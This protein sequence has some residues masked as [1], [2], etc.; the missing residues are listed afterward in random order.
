M[1]I[2]IVFVAL[3]AF[4]SVSLF[5]SDAALD[6]DDTDDPCGGSKQRGFCTEFYRRWWFNKSSNT[7]EP[8]TW[9]GCGGT[10]NTHFNESICLAECLPK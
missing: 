6:D 4:L 2:L 5:P 1:Y 7:C 3:A 9:T 10:R 8:F